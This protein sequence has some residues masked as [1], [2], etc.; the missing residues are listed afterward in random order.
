MTSTLKI[1]RASPQSLPAGDTRDS[2]PS[3]PLL[4]IA[5]SHRLAR[6]DLLG[7]HRFG[8]ESGSLP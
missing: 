6:L 3:T 7:Q 8:R 2:T 4:K 5:S 1:E